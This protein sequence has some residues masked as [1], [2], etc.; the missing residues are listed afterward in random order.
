M[1]KVV[2]LH[3]MSKGRRAVSS[4]QGMIVVLH[5]VSEE[6]RAQGMM[7]VLHYVS[8]RRRVIS[9]LSSNEIAIYWDLFLCQM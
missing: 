8:E 7:V 4:A 9:S 5:Y 1:H 2:V 3:Y 6:R